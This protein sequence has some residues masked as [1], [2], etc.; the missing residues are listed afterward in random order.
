[1]NKESNETVTQIS[2][3]FN[4]ICFVKCENYNELTELSKLGV[5]D[6][7]YTSD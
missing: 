5:I 2:I 4:K 3:R 7:P 6:L 1:M